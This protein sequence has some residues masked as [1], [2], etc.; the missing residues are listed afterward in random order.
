MTSAQAWIGVVGALLTAVGGILGYFRFQS[1]RD[2]KSAVGAAFD[3]IVDA[4]ASQAPV[5]QLAAAIM[6]R[7]F[8]DPRA[9]QGTAG[10][11]YGREAVAVIAALLRTLETGEMQK[12]LADGLGYAPSLQAADLQ[13]CN[14][15]GA[16]LGDRGH[17]PVDLSRADLFEA[18]L[19]GASLRGAIAKGTVF[20]MATLRKTVFEDADLGGADFRA[21]DLEGARFAG[22]KLGGA[23]FADAR[24]LPES[25]AGLLN[26]DG[27]VPRGEERVPR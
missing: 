3:R 4:L 2:R 17:G 20:Y 15:A 10:T 23:R 19:S 7:R 27:E 5:R 26:N 16:F 25:V 6:L 24:G 13:R 1:R 21:T 14:I 22:A 18:D 11:P 9:E 12:L 8:F